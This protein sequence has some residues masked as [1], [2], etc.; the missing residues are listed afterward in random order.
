MSEHLWQSAGVSLRV[1]LA[2]AE[3]AVRA[4][5]DDGEELALEDLHIGERVLTFRAGG[6][7]WRA[8]WYAER[9]HVWIALEGRT[10]ELVP[11][12]EAAD[13]GA[14]EAGAFRAEIT[15]P[16][17]GK[18]LAVTVAAGDIVEA[19]AALL[20]MEAMKMET[21]VRAPAPARV[22]EVAVQAAEMVGPGQ[23]LLRLEPVEE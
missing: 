8:P 17:P 4:T 19:D 9:G 1:V 22:V 6:R 12:E 21:T 20:V 3:G 18:I 2:A 11:A 14:D 16:M 15:S 10:W 13:D 5:A 23:L 7:Q